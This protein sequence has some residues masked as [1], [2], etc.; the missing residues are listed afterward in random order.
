VTLDF[1]LACNTQVVLPFGTLRRTPGGRVELV[2]HGLTSLVSVDDLA[3]SDQLIGISWTDW[4]CAVGSTSASVVRGTST[5]L[6]LGIDGQL[7][8]LDLDGR[9]DPGGLHRVRLFAVGNDSCLVDTE[10]GLGLV[11]RGV[12][13]GWSAVHDDLTAR[14][15]RVSDSEV[16]VSSESS[17]TRLSLSDGRLL[18]SEPHDLS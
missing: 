16:V 6:M 4:M 17:S 9:Y 15:V 12:G 1:E 13:V 11:R 3:D 18:G 10:M 8:R 2:Q 5:P 7:A 14:V